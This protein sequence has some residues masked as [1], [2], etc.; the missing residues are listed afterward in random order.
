MAGRHRE[1]LVSRFVEYYVQSYGTEARACPSAGRCQT[2]LAAARRWLRDIAG[3]A[4][5]LVATRPCVSPPRAPRVQAAT[6]AALALTEGESRMCTWEYLVA[7][8]E[9]KSKEGLRPLKDC[10]RLQPDFFKRT[11][12]PRGQ[13][14]DMEGRKYALVSRG[15]E[16]LN[17]AFGEVVSPGAA[18]ASCPPPAPLCPC[19]HNAGA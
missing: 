12:P 15:V 3:A 17:R 11:D 5:W 8:C 9:D 16:A 10:L 1:Y 4:Q 13:R 7:L 14:D 6:T 19:E 18:G 2:F